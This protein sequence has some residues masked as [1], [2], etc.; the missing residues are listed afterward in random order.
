MSQLVRIVS[1]HGLADGTQVFLEDGRTLGPIAS[2]EIPALRSGEMVR[3]I[4]ELPRIELDLEAHLLVSRQT[5]EESA[6]HHGLRLTDDTHPEPSSGTDGDVPMIVAHELMLLRRLQDTL[7]KYL[8]DDVP[9][10]GWEQAL[11][12]DESSYLLW[13]S[14]RPQPQESS[15]DD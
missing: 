2:I 8:R 5:L 15:D 9:D 12:D 7:R 3:A 4:V 10:A 14:E 11:R 1:K 13:M 6:A